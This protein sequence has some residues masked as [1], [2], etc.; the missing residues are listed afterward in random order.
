MWTLNCQYTDLDSFDCFGPLLQVC[1]P[2][3]CQFW[4]DCSVDLPGFVDDRYKPVYLQNLNIIHNKIHLLSGTR[5][6]KVTIKGTLH[7]DEMWQLEKYASTAKVRCSLDRSM[8]A[9]GTSVD[10]KLPLN[11]LPPHC[12]H[13][14]HHGALFKVPTPHPVQK[15]LFD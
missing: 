4:L 15:H 10:T 11:P 1:W 3:Y 12:D 14:L 6:F 9:P 7:C 8:F 13:T 2:V 5:N